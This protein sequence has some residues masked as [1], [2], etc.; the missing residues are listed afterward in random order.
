M[1]ATE[2]KKYWHRSPFIPFNIVVPGRPNLH[3]P[4]PDF[5]TVSPSG[6]IAKVWLKNDDEI[7]LDVFL[8]TAL[9]ENSRNGKA[10]RRASGK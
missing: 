5:L 1:T 10:G 9:E 4:H 6:R 7:A 3:V 8:I 2:L